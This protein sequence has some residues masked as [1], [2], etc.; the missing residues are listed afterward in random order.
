[1]GMKFTKIEPEDSILIKHYIYE[2]L[3]M[4]IGRIVPGKGPAAGQA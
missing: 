3:G 2:Q 4:E 1:M